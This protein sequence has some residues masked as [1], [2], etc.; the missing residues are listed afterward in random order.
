MH[1]LAEK[2]HLNFQTLTKISNQNAYIAHLNLLRVSL[3]ITSWAHA[4]LKVCSFSAHASYISAHVSN[5][6][7][8]HLFCEAWIFTIWCSIYESPIMEEWKILS[9]DQDTLAK[10]IQNQ[11]W[12]YEQLAKDTCKKL[13]LVQCTSPKVEPYV[14]MGRLPLH[15][16]YGLPKPDTTMKPCLRNTSFLRGALWYK[17]FLEGKNV[18]LVH[19]EFRRCGNTNSPWTWPFSYSFVRG[20]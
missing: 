16:L 8:M 9:L 11:L 10:G 5:M 18:L 1:E 6:I 20:S 4:H 15:M 14:R 12:S 3:S 13:V 7:L 2:I 19:Q 17:Y